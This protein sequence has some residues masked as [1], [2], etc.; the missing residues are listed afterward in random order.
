MKKKILAQ[1]LNIEKNSAMKLHIFNV[2]SFY[3][4]EVLFCT[5]KYVQNSERNIHYYSTV[6][7][8]KV[9]NILQPLIV[10][11]VMLRCSSPNR[12]IPVP[13]NLVLIRFD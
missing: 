13:N 12:A 9:F 11:F 6:L 8:M 1:P 3:T 4:F 10:S 2:L 5:Y 7:C